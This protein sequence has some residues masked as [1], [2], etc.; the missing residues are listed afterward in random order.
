M[1]DQIIMK[2][3]LKSKHMKKILIL[4]VYS[5][6]FCNVVI[7]QALSE[8]AMRYWYYRDRLKYFV[9]P[10]NEEGASLLMT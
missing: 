2:Y 8:E 1:K 9:Y 6:F 10:D 4:V 5:L 3:T 7:A